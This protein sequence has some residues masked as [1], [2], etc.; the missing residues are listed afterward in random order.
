MIGAKSRVQSPA[1]SLTAES[2]LETDSN[3]T[4]NDQ[5]ETT[6]AYYEHTSTPVSPVSLQH[7]QLIE[8][9][10][11]IRSLHYGQPSNTIDSLLSPQM[12]SF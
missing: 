8:T 11:S 3:H 10:D 9:V 7:E 1:Y 4:E 5:Q 12:V 2:Q 6:P